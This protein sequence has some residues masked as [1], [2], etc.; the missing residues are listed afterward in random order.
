MITYKID[1]MEELKKVGFNS[2]TAK[3]TGVLGQSV[4]NKLRKGD[5]N[6]TIENLNRLCCILEM[7]PRDILKFTEDEEDKK[8]LEK[9]KNNA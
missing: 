9:I 4:M 7:Q 6:I 8:I 1:V 3:K 2:N 5:T